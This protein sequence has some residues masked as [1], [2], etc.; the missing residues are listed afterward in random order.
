[1]FLGGIELCDEL[2]GLDAALE[3]GGCVPSP[4]TGEMLKPQKIL[5]NKCLRPS[6]GVMDIQMAGR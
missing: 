5:R 1:M 4:V 3:W 2:P 6:D